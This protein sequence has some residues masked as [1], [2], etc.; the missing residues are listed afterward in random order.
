MPLASQGCRRAALL[1]PAFP[2]PAGEA[3]ATQY[4]Q[5]AANLGMELRPQWLQGVNP[6]AP[7]WA[8]QAAHLLASLP[9]AGRPD[10]LVITDDNLAG[11]ASDGLLQAGIRV[12]EE[13]RVVAHAN[14]PWPTPCRVPATRL[15]YDIGKLLR[16]CMER[17]AEQRRGGTPPRGTLLPPL[18]EDEVRAGKPEVGRRR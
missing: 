10:G 11:P 3:L 14:F 6:L 9:K 12:P 7:G 18:F 4:G 16:I 5:L 8:S 15:G 13:L 2:Q 17:I 1:T